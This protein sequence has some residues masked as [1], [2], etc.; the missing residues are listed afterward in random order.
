L[1]FLSYAVQGFVDGL[2]AQLEYIHRQQWKLAWENYVS[3]QLI[4]LSSEIRERCFLMVMALSDHKD[5]VP[6][7]KLP[8]LNPR[9]AAFYARKTTKTLSR[10]ISLLMK[11]GLIDMSQAGVRAKKE[12]VLA[13]RPFVVPPKTQSA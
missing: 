11:K 9:A 12:T 3:A 4:G 5:P 1:P 7:P 2:V 13:F 6:V 10:D 8:E